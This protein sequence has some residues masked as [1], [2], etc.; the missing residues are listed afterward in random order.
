MYTKKYGGEKKMDIGKMLTIKG[1]IV[2]PDCIE[3]GKKI[4][5]LKM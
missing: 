2:C 3:S 1:F 5:V 4:K